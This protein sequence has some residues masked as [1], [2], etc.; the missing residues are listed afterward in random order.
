MPKTTGRGS[1]QAEAS[2]TPTAQGPEAL[3]QATEVCRPLGAYLIPSRRGRQTST[4]TGPKQKEAAYNW[5][6]SAKAK[7]SLVGTNLKVTVFAHLSLAENFQPVIITTIRDV[8]KK[9]PQKIFNSVL[10]SRS[11]KGPKSS[12]KLVKTLVNT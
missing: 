8:H 3:T 4:T 5:Q 10:T 6:C 11:K 9:S 2:K 1:T 7:L 12:T